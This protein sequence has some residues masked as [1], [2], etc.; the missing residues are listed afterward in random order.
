MSKAPAIPPLSGVSD[1]ATRTILQSIVDA[2]R[3]LTKNATATVVT[4]PASD[5]VVASSAPAISQ[6]AFN[7]LLNKRFGTLFDAMFAE[8]IAIYDQTSNVRTQALAMMAEAAFAVPLG[9]AP[10]NVVVVSGTTQAAAGSTHYIL[11]NVADTTVTLP[12]TPTAGMTIWVTSANSL[13]SNVIARNGKEIDGVAADLT[14]TPATAT[15]RLR[16]IDD[17]LMWRVV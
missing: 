17:T 5:P 4:S 11:T 7:R 16:Y 1:P 8:N 12:A 9:G 10:G 6:E 15:V 14:I 2:L 13:T 3:V